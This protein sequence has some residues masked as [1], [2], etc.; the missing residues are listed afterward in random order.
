MGII[1]LL[2]LCLQ[3][4]MR[5]QLLFWCFF[6]VYLRFY[7]AK[8]L[9]MRGGCDRLERRQA[10]SAPQTAPAGGLPQIIPA[11]GSCQE[12]WNKNAVSKKCTAHCARCIALHYNNI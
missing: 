10:P 4:L 1:M 8:A 9:D 6:C 2:V 12:T 3:L 7:A 5:E 11:R